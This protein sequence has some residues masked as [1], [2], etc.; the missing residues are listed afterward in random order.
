[1]SWLPPAAL[2]QA[3]TVDRSLSHEHRFPEGAVRA[4]HTHPPQSAPP[5][6]RSW[7]DRQAGTLSCLSIGLPVRGRGAEALL[8]P[9]VVLLGFAVVL[10]LLAT[11]VFRWD[12]V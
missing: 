2:S 3:E 7:S 12:H 4:D 11:R 5:S 6:Q 9:I 1:L 10:T 8:I